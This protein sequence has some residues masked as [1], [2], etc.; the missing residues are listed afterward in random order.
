MKANKNVYEKSLKDG[1]YFDIGQIIE[2][3]IDNYKITWGVGALTIIIFLIIFVALGSISNMVVFGL[4]LFDIEMMQ[5]LQNNPSSIY[6]WD[7]ILIATA[8][9]SLV[10]GLSYPFI[11]GILKII[12]NAHKKNIVS[13]NG[14][15]DFYKTPH[16]KDLVVAGILISAITNLINYTFISI[17]YN[18]IGALIQGLV[19]VL[20]V[21]VINIIVFCNKPYLEAI[22]DSLVLI[23]KKP[24]QII[25]LSIIGVFF[26]FIG[27]IGCGIGIVF[28]LFFIFINN[29]FMFDAIASIED[30]TND[31][32]L[33]GS[34]ETE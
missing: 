11:A 27:V 12:Y 30:D 29:Y 14:L 21:F 15:F 34:E 31:I 10:T 9:N 22:N 3:S 8:I 20:F 33:I 26:G 28:T 23:F 2:K 4:S 16:T 5:E 24:L 18:F 32:D 19:S 17:G 6:T 7:K 1:Y 13:I 25:I